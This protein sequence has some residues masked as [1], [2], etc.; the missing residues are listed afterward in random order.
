M[1]CTGLIATVVAISIAASPAAAVLSY[2]ENV[3]EHD[4]VTGP[5]Y[6]TLCHR[7]DVAHEAYAAFER[8]G[9]LALGIRRALDT[10]G[11]VLCMDLDA[12]AGQAPVDGFN[13]NAAFELRYD[14]NPEGTRAT[15]ELRVV[16]LAE[17]TAAGGRPGKLKTLHAEF[18]VLDPTRFFDV[19][20]SGVSAELTCQVEFDH[21]IMHEL[22]LLAELPPGVLATDARVIIREQSLESGRN[23]RQVLVDG[24]FS[25]SPD[26][27]F[28]VV[29][30]LECDENLCEPELLASLTF[31][32]RFLGGLSPVEATSWGAIKSHYSE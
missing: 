21:G 6:P 5:P 28:D 26:A 2:F 25:G 30:T 3:S 12:V 14:P 4:V 13:D 11:D 24:F 32:G 1:R 27:N 8:D 18:P 20:V 19:H 17:L 23:G 9:Q 31:S 7:A 10:A 29:L 22:T 15:R 16:L